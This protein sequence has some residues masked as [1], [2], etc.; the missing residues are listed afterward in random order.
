MDSDKTVEVSLVPLLPGDLN[1]SDRVNLGD[2]GLMA[3]QWGRNGEMVYA[4]IDGEVMMEAERYSNMSDG[5]GVAEGIAWCYRSEGSVPSNGYM[6]C[7]PDTGE[8]VGTNITNQAPRLRYHVYF[9]AAGLYY[10]WIKGRAV[11]H[12]AD[13]LYF[14]LDGLP[15]ATVARVLAE[16][17]FAWSCQ[18]IYSALTP[19]ILNITTSGWHEVDIWM[20][21]DGVELDCLL[22]TD[23]DNYV[24][25]NPVESPHGLADVNENG[26]VDALDLAIL[27]ENWLNELTE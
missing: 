24:P 20:C 9:P 23:D 25:V 11:D 8:Y 21:E 19:T 14:G 26:I 13:S 15:S 12:T 22:L 4:L 17:S 7:L 6:H 16:P 5:A 2:L 18:E 1:F 27:A 3:W 10:F